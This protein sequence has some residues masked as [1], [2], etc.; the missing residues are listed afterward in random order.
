MGDFTFWIKFGLSLKFGFS[1]R[2]LQKM[3][4]PSVSVFTD[5]TVYLLTI[6]HETYSCHSG[7]SRRSFSVEILSSAAQ[8]LR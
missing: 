1:E 4:S 8:D 5:L 7:T 2:L 3:K 6:S